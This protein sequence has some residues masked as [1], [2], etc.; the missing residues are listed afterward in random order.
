M[1]QTIFLV[2]MT[3]GTHSDR[4][5]RPVLSYTLEASARNYCDSQNREIDITEGKI[6]ALESLQDDWIASHPTPEWDY[7]E[8][9]LSPDHPYNVWDKD[10]KVE[11]ARLSR[12]IFG[13]DDPPYSDSPRYYYQEVP[14]DP[15]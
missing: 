9:G 14:L 6:D 12:L 10:R 11:H 2:L 7:S 3:L 8:T 1:A 13:Q 15:E 5:I 4:A